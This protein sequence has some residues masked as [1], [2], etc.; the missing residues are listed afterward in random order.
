[1]IKIILPIVKSSFSIYYDF[2][3]EKDQNLKYKLEKYDIEY[4]YKEQKNLKSYIKKSK[5]RYIIPYKIYN[6]IG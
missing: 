1:M 6:I 5:T 3:L 2:L 4:L